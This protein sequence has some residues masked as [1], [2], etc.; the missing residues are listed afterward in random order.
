MEVQDLQD[1]KEWLVSQVQGEMLVSVE[2]V[3]H[4]VMLG[5]R[6]SLERQEILELMVP[7]VKLDLGVTLDFKDNPEQVDKQVH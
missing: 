3:D 2:I 4:L 1:R 6:V 5:L 7:R